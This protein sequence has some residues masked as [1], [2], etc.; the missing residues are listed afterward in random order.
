MDAVGN[1]LGFSYFYICL[2]VKKLISE[3]MIRFG[4]WNIST[5]IFGK[6]MEKVDT[7]I[8]RKINFMGLQEI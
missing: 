1:N 6:F 5:F 2:W 4:S 8:R 3:S 7:M